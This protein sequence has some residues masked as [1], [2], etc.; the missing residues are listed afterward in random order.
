MIQ[1][2]RGLPELT[3]GNSNNL[4][5]QRG[6]TGGKN[7]NLLTS[8]CQLS[9]VQDIYHQCMKLHHISRAAQP[10]EKLS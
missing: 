10:G 9:V 1:C 3:V 2:L 6:P 5:Y 7:N 4:N 8:N